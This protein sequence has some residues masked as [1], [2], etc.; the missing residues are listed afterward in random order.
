MKKIFI[1]FAVFFIFAL[2][3]NAEFIL[4][5]A[6][7]VDSKEMSLAGSYSIQQLVDVEILNGADK[8]K[9]LQLENIVSGNPYYD[10]QVKNNDKLLLHSEQEFGQNNYFIADIFRIVPLLT[11]AFVFCA[12]VLIVAKRKGLY[13]LLSILVTVL[14]IFKVLCPLILIGVSPLF[15]TLLISLVSTLVT[16]YL[17]GGVNRKSTSATVGT[18]VSL[19]V[20]GIASL[21]TIKFANLTGFS[22]ETT[23][24]VYTSYPNL[25]FV[26]ITASMI[27]LAALGAVM[28]VAMSIA[29]TINEIYLNNKALG[30][31]KLFEAGMNVGKDI[32][33]TMANT[34]ILVYMGSA[35]P[36]LLLSANIDAGKFFNLNAVVTE[37]SS[38]IIGSIALLLCVPITAIVAAN[39]VRCD[40]ENIENRD[41]IVENSEEE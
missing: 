40:N 39:L 35:L 29:S 30:V 7:N 34:L 6:L 17:V 28:D 13:S 8:G 11:L 38:A 1:L 15:A 16:M 26:S 4:G 19:F 33:G 18:I 37:I 41:I 27:I 24:F 14:L 21:L 36:L 2:G 22:D 31:K 9:V 12:L 20:A 23:L 10:I 32:I 3:A 5:K 25:N